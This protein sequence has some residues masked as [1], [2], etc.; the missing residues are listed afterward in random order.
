VDS[1][2]RDSNPTV[3]TAALGCPVLSEA[4]GS[5]EARPGFRSKI[6]Q[7]QSVASKDADPWHKSGVKGAAGRVLPPPDV[8]IKKGRKGKER[9]LSAIACIERAIASAPRLR[10][11]IILRTKLTPSLD[12]RWRSD[13]LPLG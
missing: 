7:M 3:G 4:G 2:L 12:L 11:L 13:C 6:R 10:N 1:N 8:K 9:S 5:S